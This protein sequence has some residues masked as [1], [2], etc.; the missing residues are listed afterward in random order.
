MPEI[1]ELAIETKAPDGGTAFRLKVDWRVLGKALAKG[2]LNLSFGKFDSALGSIVDA[3][4]AFKKKPGEPLTP[5]EQAWLW[6][7]QG[8]AAA[9]GRTIRSSSY[10]IEKRDETEKEIEPFVTGAQSAEP[11]IITL[12]FFVHPTDSAFFERVCTGVKSWLRVLDV[13]DDE[14]GKIIRRLGQEFPIALDMEERERRADYSAL[15]TFFQP[16]L[17]SAEAG[18]Q[19][20]WRRYRAR[21]V[22]EIRKPLLNLH[23][24][25]PGAVSL[26][27]I[28]VPLRAV[29][30]VPLPEGAA[31][32]AAERRFTHA[33]R[34]DR[35]HIFVW[36]DEHIDNWV[37]A[38]LS[39]DAMRIVAGDPGSG[40]SS[41]GMIAAARWALEERRVLRV[42]L[43]LI[44]FDRDAFAA[45]RAFSERE[46]QLGVDPLQG[47]TS[48]EPLV[49]ILDGL[50]ELSRVNEQSG[51]A[52]R[53]FVES[54][55][56]NVFRENTSS[57]KARLL[58]L[59]A[60]RPIVMRQSTET[61]RE[62]GQRVDILR[63]RVDEEDYPNLAAPDDL[64]I[65]QRDTWWQQYGTAT[66]QAIEGLPEEYRKGQRQI[67]DITAQPLLNYLL[68]LVWEERRKSP[69]AQAIHSVHALYTEIFELLYRRR[70]GHLASPQHV[71]ARFE[72][73]DYKRLLEE[74]AIS[75]WHTGD[76]SVTKQDIEARFKVSDP[77]TQE[78]IKQHYG[79]LEDGVF[80]ILSSFFVAPGLGGVGVYTF[81]HKSFREFLTASRLVREVETIVD[82]LADPRSRYTPEK[83]LEDWYKLSCR[84]AMDP[85][86]LSFVREEVAARCAEETGS[87]ALGDWH[88][89]LN[90]LFEL[91]LH[92][93]MPGFAKAENFREAARRNSNAEVG[94][95]ALLGSCRRDNILF[96]DWGSRTG[97]AQFLRDS[98]LV[99]SNLDVVKSCLNKTDLHKQALPF[100]D[101]AFANLE[102]ANLRGA[103]LEGANLVGA[104]LEGAD[105]RGANLEGA[106]LVG[107]NLVG[108]YLRGAY[109]RGANL[110]G[111]NLEGA[112]LVGAHLGGADLRG[113]NLV[114]ANLEGANFKG[115]YLWGANLEGV[116]GA[117]FEGA[118]FERRESRSNDVK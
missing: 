48:G 20:A 98:A 41:F 11:V 100:L 19:R 90:T 91:N 13:A 105:L 68:A 27:E 95:F 78:L 72:Q 34:K 82:L 108:A 74:V 9:L 63:F 53:T 92:E 43:H 112:K 86:L 101:L 65:D 2:A 32:G 107:A 99:L 110:V 6:L 35:M 8:T 118:I 83:A 115:A 42:P 103:N 77:Q 57:D 102:G 4:D 30:D 29:Y 22:E 5:G 12:A 15:A 59:L 18:R 85:D 84:A 39:K 31:D 56:Q 14:Q 89:A 37:S 45:I 7:H 51:A 10:F 62:P 47:L 38:A 67:D 96:V 106:N 71:E 75:A 52:A 16:T 40:K 33:A 3:A 50:D 104:H 61:L 17:I 36:L 23:T 55:L 113:A 49:L 54:V 87:K 70:K 25:E 66:G 111:A 116:L 1:D 79:C 76:R 88:S 21:L 80:A 94:L 46:D 44:D 28:F 93:G 97:A 69:A 26:E 60:G 109:L 114:G 117:N 24:N 58:A 73:S 64:R 81:T